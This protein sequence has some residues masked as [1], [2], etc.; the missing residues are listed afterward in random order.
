MRRYSIIAAVLLSLALTG[1][2]RS[3]AVP[4]SVNFRYSA[5][6]SNSPPG[7]CG[8][9]ALQGAAADATWGNVGPAGGARFSLAVD[10]GVEHTGHVGDAPYGLTLTTL[11]AGPR[12]HLPGQRV[13]IFGQV[14]LG[15]AHGAD[16]EF[17]HNNSLESSANSFALDLGGGIDLASHS[18]ISLRVL[19]L[20]YVRT[21]FPNT[22]SNWQSNFRLGAG[23]TLHFPR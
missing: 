6:I 14:L 3:Q 18:R 19:Q 21:G 9:F 5:Q 22:S 2:A 17:P 13:H 16:S 7:S 4:G 12:M 11:T 10:A 15:W 23:V 8:C 1:T 20:D